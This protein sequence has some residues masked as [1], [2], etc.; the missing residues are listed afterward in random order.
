MICT[1]AEQLSC[2]DAEHAQDAVARLFL[3]RLERVPGERKGDLPLNQA[4]HLHL[5]L[6]VRLVE[7]GIELRKA[8]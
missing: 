7:L 2:T 1:D 5:A 3:M 4:Y 6:G 8:S